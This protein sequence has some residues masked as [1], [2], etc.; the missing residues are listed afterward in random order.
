MKQRSDSK[1]DGSNLVEDIASNGHTLLVNIISNIPILMKNTYLA[2]L[3]APWFTF[4]QPDSADDDPAISA[5]TGG[6]NGGLKQQQI[7][8]ESQGPDATTH[9]SKPIKENTTA[10]INKIAA[11]LDELRRR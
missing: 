4:P 9:Q 1:E 8:S 11:K 5:P 10:T 6:I 7:P 2:K 3:T